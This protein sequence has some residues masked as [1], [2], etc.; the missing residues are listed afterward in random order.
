ME[1]TTCCGRSSSI[2]SSSFS[3]NFPVRTRTPA[4]PAR[5][6]PRTSASR[7]SPTITASL[8]PTPSVESA[9]AKNAPDGLPSTTASTSAAFSR[10]SRNAPASSCRPAS[11]RQ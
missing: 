4:I 3:V 10:P 7:S 5:W 11:V 2:P 1:S 8:R 9:A 6:A